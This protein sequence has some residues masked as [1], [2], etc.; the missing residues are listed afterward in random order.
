MLKRILARFAAWRTTPFDPA[1]D[2]LLIAFAARL[3]KLHRNTPPLCQACDSWGHLDALAVAYR[4]DSARTKSDLLAVCLGCAGDL[5][6]DALPVRLGAQLHRSATPVE[7]AP[8]AVL[9]VGEP[10]TYEPVGEPAEY[11]YVSP[12]RAS[13]AVRRASI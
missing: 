9:D 1:S 10:V 11:R 4:P 12:R 3:A 13:N 5:E 7:R 8:V 6:L 2:A